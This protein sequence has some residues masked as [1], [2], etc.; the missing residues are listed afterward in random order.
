MMRVL[1]VA[2][3]M[4]PTVALARG[5]FPPGA[6]HDW[7]QC[8]KQPVTGYSCCSEADG[9]TLEDNEWRMID[10]DKGPKY[11]VEI[12]GKWYDVPSDTVINETAQCGPEPNTEKRFKA[13]VWFYPINIGGS[14]VDIHIYCFMSGVMT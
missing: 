14:I 12:E 4:L 13:K 8:Q 10:S 1:V 2:L 7:W 6:E 5:N 9:R 11:Q 3:A